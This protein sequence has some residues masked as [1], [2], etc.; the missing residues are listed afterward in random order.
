MAK[1]TK[2]SIG[3]DGLTGRAGPPPISQVTASGYGRSGDVR[4]KLTNG[5]WPDW[6]TVTADSQRMDGKFTVKLHGGNTNDGD[7]DYYQQAVVIYLRAIEIAHKLEQ[8]IANP[9]WWHSEDFEPKAHALGQPDYVLALYLVT[10]GE[11]FHYGREVPDDEDH[12]D[13]KNDTRVVGLDALRRMAAE[14]IEAGR[15]RG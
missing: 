8:T 14:H 15:A 2:S 9:D 7:S 12:V 4:I 10:K 13:E 5:Y 11:K 1:E 3:A 6:L